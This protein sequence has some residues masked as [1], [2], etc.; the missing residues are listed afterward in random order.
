M[1]VRRGGTTET[2]PSPGV[3]VQTVLTRVLRWS[4]RRA[5]RRLLF[6]RDAEE[7]S[8]NDVWLLDAVEANGPVRLSDLAFWQGVDKSTITP[9][10]RRLETR[11]LVERKSSADD[12]RAALLALTTKGQSVQ[13]RRAATGA[14]LIDKLLQ[15]WPPHDRTEFARLFRLF[16]DQ[17]EAHPVPPDSPPPSSH[18]R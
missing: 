15:T 8:Q 12:R 13:Q 4:T 1:A 3:L 7:L 10:V 2:S 6:G 5:N 14:A 9:Q 17:L 18:R 11:G 16:A